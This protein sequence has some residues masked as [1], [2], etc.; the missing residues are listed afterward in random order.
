MR[1]ITAH[2]GCDGTEDNSLEFVKYAIAAGADGLEVDVRKNK[3]G[4]LFLSHD[5]TEEEGVKLCEVFALLKRSPQLKINCDLKSKDLEMPVYQLAKE[6]EVERQLIYSGEVSLK[7]LYQKEKEFPEVEIYLNIENLLQEVPC[8]AARS[9]QSQLLEKMLIQA[10]NY[11]IACINMEYHLFTEEVM[12]VLAQIGLGGSA[13]TV[14]EPEDII[15][16]L[17]KDIINIT[18]RN[19]KKALEL[20]EEMRR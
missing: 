10:K 14:N 2:S 11:P 7:Q 16:L 12:A 8:E 3:A 20:R 18:T 6:F 1:S 19:L 13:W 5:D 9:D 17:K 15:W 4:N